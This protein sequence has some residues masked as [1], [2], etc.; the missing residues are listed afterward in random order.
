MG[1]GMDI[2]K[3]KPSYTNKQKAGTIKYIMQLDKEE[4]LSSD[5]DGIITLNKDTKRN[6]INSVFTT[7]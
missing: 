6:H 3:M 2:M 7:L 1:S 4:K 5:K